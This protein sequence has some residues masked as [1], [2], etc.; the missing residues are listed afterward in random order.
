LILEGIFYV[1]A[2]I[3]IS[4]ASFCA[5]L[6]LNIHYKGFEEKPV[7]KILQFI[8]FK[9][10]GKVLVIYNLYFKFKINP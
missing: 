6:A 1:S 4:M 10:M 7:P 2:R 5:I 3:I 8:F 9:R